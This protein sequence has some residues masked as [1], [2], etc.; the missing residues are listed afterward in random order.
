VPLIQWPA[1][2]TIAGANDSLF[3]DLVYLSEILFPVPYASKPRG[4]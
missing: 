1:G 3:F 4:S 2:G